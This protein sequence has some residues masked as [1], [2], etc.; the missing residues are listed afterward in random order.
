MDIDSC[1]KRQKLQEIEFEVGP[2]TFNNFFGQPL[3]KTPKSLH[4]FDPYPEISIESHASL[5]KAIFHHKL[6]SIPPSGPLSIL[7]NYLDFLILN[8]N[9]VINPLP[10]I[11]THI[12]NH[13][14]KYK[15]LINNNNLA[16][17]S[18]KD[19]AFTPA[20]VMIIV[21]SQLHARTF[22]EALVKLHCKE[23][24]SYLQ[25]TAKLSLQLKTSLL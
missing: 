7:S 23:K 25:K 13:V 11:Y 6:S 14:Y 10:E 3:K 22:I 8:S 17:S 18:Q 1:S 5:S 21:P 20:V 19:Q 4:S 16:Q 2:D 9:P 12:L 24:P 15:T